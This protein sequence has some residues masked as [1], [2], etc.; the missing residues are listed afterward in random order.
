MVILTDAEVFV[1]RESMIAGVGE[2][3]LIWNL[4]GM[5]PRSGGIPATP[6]TTVSSQG[7]KDSCELINPTGLIHAEWRILPSRGYR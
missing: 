2:P 4:T 5:C 7:G 6:R 3:C 1:Y